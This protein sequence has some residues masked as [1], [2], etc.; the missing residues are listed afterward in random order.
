[1]RHILNAKT[2]IPHKI[3]SFEGRFQRSGPVNN[4]ARIERVFR[5]LS[6]FVHPDQNPKNKERAT[7]AFKRL[8]FSRTKLL[9]QEE[10]AAKQKAEEEATKKKAEEEAAKKKTEEEAAKQEAEEEAAKQKMKKAPPLSPKF[11]Q[12]VDERLKDQ[13]DLCDHILAFAGTPP[14]TARVVFEQSQKLEER[15]RRILEEERRRKGEVVAL[16]HKAFGFGRGNRSTKRSGAVDETVGEICP[17]PD[18]CN[19]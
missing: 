7:R 13:H 6:F 16:L 8:E 9:E 5:R 19:R 1:M 10:E 3:F 12:E 2:P 14:K 4:S 11:V 18:R 17:E 15:H